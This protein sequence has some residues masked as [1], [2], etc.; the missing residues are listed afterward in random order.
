ML[1]P[2]MNSSEYRTPNNS[3]FSALESRKYPQESEVERCVGVRGLDPTDHGV[4]D[5]KIPSIKLCFRAFPLFGIKISNYG[6][7]FFVCDM[8]GLVLGRLGAVIEEERL[9]GSSNYFFVRVLRALRRGRGEE[10][11]SITS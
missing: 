8:W 10:K 11:R 6:V 3:Q 1:R 2:C 7:Y 9:G 4:A 5:R